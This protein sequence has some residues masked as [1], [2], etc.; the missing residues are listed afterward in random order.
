[1]ITCINRSLIKY[2]ESEIFPI[3]TTFDE[4]HNL[5]HIYAVIRRAIQISEEIA[6]IDMNIVYAS[7][8]L[9]DIGIQIERKN[10]AAHSASFVRNNSKLKNF[11]TEEEIEIIAQAVEDHSTSNGIIPRNVYGKI[12]ADADKDDDIDVSLLRAYEFVKSYFP[13]YTE[14][15]CFKNVYEQLVNK[16]GPNGKVRFFIKSKNHQNFVQQMRLLSEDEREFEQ[17]LRNVISKVK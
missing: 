10:H 1:M 12:V 15:E 14:E 8:A 6:G 2:M 11:F 16:F 5:N 7:A 17:R 3:Y 13:N 9:H 4:G